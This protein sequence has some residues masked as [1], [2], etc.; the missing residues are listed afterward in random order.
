MALTY[1]RLLFS[2]IAQ[3]ARD[4]AVEFSTTH[5]PNSIKGTISDLPNVQ[6]QL[7]KSN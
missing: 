2:G 3:A 5:S 7:E 6:T 4:F 1:S